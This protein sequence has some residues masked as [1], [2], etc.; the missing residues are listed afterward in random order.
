MIARAIRVAGALACIGLPAA[1][2]GCGGGGN[3]AAARPLPPGVREVSFRSPALDGTEHYTV[4]VPPGYGRSARRY[5]VVYLLHGLPAKAST[6]RNVGVERF[7]RAAAQAGLPVIVIAPQGARHGEGEPEWHDWG[8]GRDWETA[9]ASDVV[10]DADH[11]FRTIADPRDRTLIGASAGGYGAVAIGLDHPETFS[12]IESWSGYFRPTNAKGTAPVAFKTHTAQVTA[13]AHRFV[14]CLGQMAGGERPA[15][16]GFFVGTHN[17]LYLAEN[18]QLDAELTAAHV[19]HH[20]TVYPG[21]RAS[22]R[23]H[24][25]QWLLQG[26]RAMP[27]SAPSGPPPASRQATGSAGCPVS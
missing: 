10:R 14:G 23:V 2:A 12:V 1:L 11:R 20:F 7:G 6:F 19:P 3:S 15:F 24:E 27:Q 9:V 18:R 5:P 21:S 22:L 4:Y 26:V 16:L 17:A 13:D 25:Q 8:A